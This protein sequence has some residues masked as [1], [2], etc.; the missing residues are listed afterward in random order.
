VSKTVKPFDYDDDYRDEPSIDLGE[1]MAQV[2]A[3][4]KQQSDEPASVR[5]IF[6]DRLAPSLGSFGLAVP[7]LSAVKGG[8]YKTRVDQALMVAGAAQFGWESY[9]RVKH[10]VH[11]RNERRQPAEKQSVTLYVPLGDE[12]ATRLID[13]VE[14][15][16]EQVAGRRTTTEFELTGEYTEHETG[17]AKYKVETEIDDAKRHSTFKLGPHEYTLS[18]HTGKP[19]ELDRASGGGDNH[20]VLRSAYS[21]KLDQYLYIQCRGV[22]AVER[23]KQLVLELFPPVVL[24]KHRSRSTLFTFDAVKKD[25]QARYGSVYRSLESV[26]LADNAA[27][28]IVADIERFLKLEQDYVDYGLTWRRGILLYGPPGTGKTSFVTALASHMEMSIYYVSLRDI[29]SNDNLTRA[30]REVNDRSIIVFEDVDV[31]VP[32]RDGTTGVTL[33][34]LLN[35]VDGM[36]TPH[37][38]IFVM[39]T[40]HIEKLDPALT[41]PGRIDLSVE[42]GNLTDAQA[43]TM[44]SRFLGREVELPPV[45]PGIMPAAVS[46]VFKNFL[47]N[48]DAALPEIIAMI[49]NQPET[50]KAF[51]E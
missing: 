11:E 19:G 29:G 5:A 24:G 21:M 40:N 51:D 39:T 25:W 15:Q 3:K 37:G 8:R 17:L 28:R 45:A 20:D 31:V 34:A 22:E 26:V 6:G 50:V 4:K 35:I 48:R 38:A 49:T 33:D 13:H 1:I 10:W 36:F 23:L 12:I 27:E 47:D 2:Q 16:F 14:E 41:R 9:K 43:T 30:I 46:G 32:G 7:L 18:V 42:L 44:V